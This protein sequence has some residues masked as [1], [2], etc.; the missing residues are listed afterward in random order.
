M[1]EER[2]LKRS[3]ITDY[4]N[5]GIKLDKCTRSTVLL[6]ENKTIKCIQQRTITWYEFLVTI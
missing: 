1:T 3:C 5:E 6:D 2:L 4:F